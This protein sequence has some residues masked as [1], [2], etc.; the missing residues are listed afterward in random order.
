MMGGGW[1][2]SD[3]IIGRAGKKGGFFFKARDSK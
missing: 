2:H 1:Y 3:C